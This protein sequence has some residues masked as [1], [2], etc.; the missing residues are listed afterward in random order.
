[1][2]MLFSWLESQEDEKY[3]RILLAQMSK[4]ELQILYCQSLIDENFHKYLVRAK[5][6]VLLEKE[7]KSII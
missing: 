6:D 1:M 4:Y 5:I 3:A 7:F 2:K